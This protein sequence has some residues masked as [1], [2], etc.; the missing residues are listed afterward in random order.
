MIPKQP[1]WA[2]K[3]F[4]LFRRALAALNR[5]TPAAFMMAQNRTA[6]NPR[7]LSFLTPV[8]RSSSLMVASTPARQRVGI[9]ER[10]GLLPGPA[11]RQAGLTVSDGTDALPPGASL[12]SRSKSTST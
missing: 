1:F 6:P 7:T 10:F 4:A 12:V 5:F 9:Q 8:G 3:A 2:A 11:L